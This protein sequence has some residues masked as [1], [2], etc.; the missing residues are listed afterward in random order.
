MPFIVGLIYISFIMFTLF[1]VVK[2][3]SNSYKNKDY[4]K[5]KAVNPID[6]KIALLIVLCTMFMYYIIGYLFK[7]DILNAIT[8]RKNGVSYSFIG[9]ILLFVTTLIIGYVI[10]KISKSRE[11]REKR[12]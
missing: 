6:K 9:V 12:F 5:N 2:D 1:L 3:K 4:N 8:F 7:T 11:R 10:E